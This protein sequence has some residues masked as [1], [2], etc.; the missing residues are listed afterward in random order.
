MRL[1]VITILFITS[2]SPV[3]ACSY[4][5]SGCMQGTRENGMDRIY[6]EKT[7][8]TWCKCLCKNKRNS[9]E[10]ILSACTPLLNVD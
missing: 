6:S 9:R 8:K 3:I 10:E 4:I 5:V 7:R 1:L 2:A